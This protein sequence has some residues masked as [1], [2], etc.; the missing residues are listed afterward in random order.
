MFS[1]FLR[2]TTPGNEHLLSCP[3]PR[4]A[5]PET[6]SRFLCKGETFQRGPIE[7]ILQAEMRPL[8]K[9]HSFHQKEGAMPV[10]KK[11]PTTSAPEGSTPEPSS[12]VLPNQEEFREHLRRLAVSAVQVLIEQ[13]MLEELEQ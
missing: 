10:P 1:A 12:P 7:V 3:H 11:K 5:F 2:G 6:P 9:R 4:Q 8:R 13:V